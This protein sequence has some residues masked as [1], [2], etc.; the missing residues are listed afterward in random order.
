MATTSSKNLL[1]SFAGRELTAGAIA[2]AGLGSAALNVYGATQIF[3]NLYTAWIFGLVITACELIAFLSLRHILADF[4]NR[5][6]WKVMGA[7]IIFAFSI[8]GCVISGKQA[9]HVLFLE[10]DHVHKSLVVRADARKKE[11]DAYHAQ[12]LAG[13]LDIDQN[14]AKARWETK[15]KLADDARLAELKAKPPHVAIVFVLL[16][17]FEMVKIGGLWFIATPTTK[18]QTIAQRR[19]YKR[20]RAIAEAEADRKH[21]RKLA[22]LIDDEVNGNVVPLHAEA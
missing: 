6:Y 5:R 18:G 2:V 1:Q 22:A 10:A 7:T 15:Q 21:K 11:A 20:Q 12:I 19:A 4:E 16:A 13:D 14:T 17:L 8:A 3:P 9:F